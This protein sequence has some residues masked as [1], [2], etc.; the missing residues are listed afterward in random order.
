MD[1]LVK[2]SNEMDSSESCPL[3]CL[4]AISLEASDKNGKNDEGMVAAWSTH[5]EGRRAA[6]WS[7]YKKTLVDVY[8]IK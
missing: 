4:K 1:T 3:S 8:R 7:N 2:E 5:A 6:T